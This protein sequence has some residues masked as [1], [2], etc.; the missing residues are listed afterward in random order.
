MFDSLY[1]AIHREMDKLAEK[2]E[3]GAQMTEVDLRSID[4]M[5][6]ALKCLATYSAMKETDRGRKRYRD[7]YEPEYRRY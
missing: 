5:A 6:H 7:Y 3:N 4:T 1:D 2:Y